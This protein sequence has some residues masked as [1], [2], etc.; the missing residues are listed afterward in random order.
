MKAVEQ[1]F[2]YQGGW[3]R[4]PTREIAFNH[5]LSRQ[6]KELW[7]WLASVKPLST[8]YTWKDCESTLRIAPRHRTRCL[9]QLVALGFIELKFRET[10]VIVVMKDPYKAYERNLKENDDIEAIVTEKDLDSEPLITIKPKTEPSL[11]KRQAKPKE[12]NAKSSMTAG[13]DQDKA[14]FL[15]AWNKYKPDSYKALYNISGKRW[16]S[17]FRHMQNLGHDTKDIDGFI[18]AVCE[19]IPKSE[20]WGKKQESR[21]RGFDNLFGTG[22]VEAVKYRNVTECYELGIS[23]EQLVRNVA[24]VETHTYDPVLQSL[25]YRLNSAKN[26]GDTE[27]IETLQKKLDQHIQLTQGAVTGNAES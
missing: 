21:Y 9:G 18:K 23:G 25:T 4:V 17:L 16:E 3:V 20:L 22:N 15:E 1:D 26:R 8:R 13:T 5:D 27:K 10:G 11:T 14:A 19:G 12:N 6:T 7:I 24:E 2:D